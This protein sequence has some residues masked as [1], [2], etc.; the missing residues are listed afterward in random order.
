MKVYKMKKLPV[1]GAA[2]YADVGQLQRRV[3]HIEAVLNLLGVQFA[4]V[5][6]A[7]KLTPET[8]DLFEQI[9]PEDLVK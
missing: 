8:K 2:N 4:E 7:T 9:N 1:G 6:E 3:E 5:D